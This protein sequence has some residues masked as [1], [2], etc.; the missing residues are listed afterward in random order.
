MTSSPS[1]SDHPTRAV[2]PV[3]R[4]RFKRLSPA[5]KY[6]VLLVVVVALLIAGQVVLHAM[7]TEPRDGRMIADRELHLNVLQPNERL[8]QVISVVQRSPMDYFRATHGILALTNKRIVYL[9]LR[10]RDMLAPADAPATF[11]ER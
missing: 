7:K 1:P 5:A 6:A 10:P 4:S 9:G 8:D 2:R 3:S 11:D